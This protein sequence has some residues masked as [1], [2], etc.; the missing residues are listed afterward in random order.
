LI[1]DD[2]PEKVCRQPKILVRIEPNNGSQ[3]DMERKNIINR[4]KE[5]QQQFDL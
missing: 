5:K 1:V 4:I 3:D 2:S